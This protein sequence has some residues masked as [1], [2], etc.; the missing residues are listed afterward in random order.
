MQRSEPQNTCTTNVDN[1]CGLP[2][3][4]HLVD[5]GLGD[6]DLP[7]DV[8]RAPLRSD[9]FT[10][11]GDDYYSKP[12]PLLF[13]PQ[14]S[15]VLTVTRDRPMDLLYFHF[16]INHTARGLMVHDCSDNPFRTILPE[17]RS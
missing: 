9:V 3:E 4:M 6:R 7:C 15:W 5:P 14:L 16:F 17:S 8:T 10:N 2:E 13:A 12:V 11:N 1:E